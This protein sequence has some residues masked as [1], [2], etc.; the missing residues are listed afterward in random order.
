M[1]DRAELSRQRCVTHWQREAVARCPECRRFFCRECVTE[2]ED[3]AICAMCLS[4]QTARAG[5]KRHPF[6]PVLRSAHL[7]L[8]VLVAWLFFYYAGRILLSLPDS[9]HEGTLWEEK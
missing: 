2:H 4:K 9:F 1:M 8:G 5:E 3:R 6:R 7:L